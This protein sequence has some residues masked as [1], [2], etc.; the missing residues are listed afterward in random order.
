[1]LALVGCATASGNDEKK[2]KPA[3]KATT[4]AETQAQKDR[5]VR[6]INLALEQGQIDTAAALVVRLRFIDP[7]NPEA[8]IARGEILVRQSHYG[9]A[10]EVFSLLI[11]DKKLIARAH[12]GRGLANLQMGNSFVAMGELK[13]AVALNKELWRSWNALGYYYDTVQ[14]WDE[15]EKNYNAALAIRQDKPSIYN[16]RGSSKLMQRRYQAALVDFG[17]ALKLDPNLTVARMNIRLTLAWLGRYVEA[18]AGTA[19]TELPAVLN[20]VGYIAMIKGEYA[21]AEAYFARA[22]E[23]SPSFHEIAATNLKKLEAFKSR[24]RASKTGKKR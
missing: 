18:I 6:D 14:K 8:L 23:L 7:K 20:N 21:A 15:A 12:Q 2:P 16:N 11:K 19:K 3:V 5:F 24:Q 13:K 9:R 10:I 4:A 1:M 17:A 22:M